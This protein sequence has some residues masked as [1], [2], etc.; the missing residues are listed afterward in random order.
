MAILNTASDR[1]RPIVPPENLSTVMRVATTEASP[2][3]PRDFSCTG[4]IALRLFDDGSEGIEV[5][6]TEAFPAL[7]CGGTNDASEYAGVDVGEWV[8]SD[9]KVFYK[10]QPYSL[11][12]ALL[13][14]SDSVVQAVREYVKTHQRGAE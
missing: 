10:N 3:D 13:L 5:D 4:R 7:I 11:E 6:L 1:L 9:F 8:L 2:V 12:K 14:A